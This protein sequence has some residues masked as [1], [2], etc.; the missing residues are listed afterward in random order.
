ML[1]EGCCL[2][3]DIIINKKSQISP[4][5]PANLRVATAYR[6]NRI[7]KY[8]CFDH[9]R[10]LGGGIARAVDGATREK[11]VSQECL[12]INFKGKTEL[13]MSA[14]MIH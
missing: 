11:Q 10:P 3:R 1:L 5:M 13:F 7:H 9:I 6:R 8:G 12:N 2:F 4:I 14:E